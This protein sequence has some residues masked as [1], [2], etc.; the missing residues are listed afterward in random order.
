M[1]VRGTVLLLLAMLVGGAAGWA[2]ADRSGAPVIAEAAPVP[3][4]AA[5]PAI[6]YTPPLK[7]KPDSDLPQLPVSFVT[8]DERL[9]EPG[10]GGVVLPVPN[11]WLRTELRPGEARWQPAGETPGLYSLRV[12]VVDLQ[13]TLEQ[14]VDERAAALP[15]DLRI[16]ELTIR[17]QSVDTL[18]AVFIIDGYSRLQVTRWLS[19]DGNG[20]D[21]EVSATGRQ[22]DEAGLDALVAKVATEAYRQ[23]P[24]TPRP[25]SIA[26]P[27]S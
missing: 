12:Q 11:G 1:G 4:S 24:N 14:A 18:R 5:D 3:V 13:R 21:L 20:V 25:G 22:I 27:S 9:G 23:Q 26:T 8:H 2:Y 10:Q 6:P 19:F 15:G 7:T 17:D 16:S